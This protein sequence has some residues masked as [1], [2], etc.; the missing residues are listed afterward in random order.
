MT[1]DH[2]VVTG[3]QAAVETNVVTYYIGILHMRSIANFTHDANVVPLN[4]EAEFWNLENHSW[5]EN[6]LFVLPYFSE[7]Y[8][9]TLFESPI[10][11]RL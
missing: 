9:K 11:K 10:S 3:F 2:W 8:R 5:L 7:K 4:D 1:I 6:K